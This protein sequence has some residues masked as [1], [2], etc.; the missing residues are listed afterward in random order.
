MRVSRIAG[1]S[2]LEAS[3]LRS[4]RISTARDLAQ[5]LDL[6]TLAAYTSI[7]V[8]RIEQ[9]A[10][11]A[12]DSLKSEDRCQKMAAWTGYVSVCLVYFIG[13][14]GIQNGISPRS[15]AAF[16]EYNE[17]NQNKDQG[18]IDAAI[19]NYRRAIRSKPDFA[20][21]YDQLGDIYYTKR[22]L[23]DAIR[24][25][26]I[27]IEYAPSVP[28]YHA[29]L[30]FAYYENH[31]YSAAITEIQQAISL[32][33]AS[34]CAQVALGSALI[35]EERYKEAISPLRRSSGTWNYTDLRECRID[36]A[37]VYSNLGYAYAHTQQ[38][39]EAIEAFRSAIRLRSNDADAHFE[40]GNT[41][42]EDGDPQGAL[43]EYQKAKAIN[44]HLD[45]LQ[46]AIK[47]AQSHLE[48]RRY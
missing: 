14:W 17:G 30:G 34:P 4:A 37:D 10:L 15:D 9:L 7:P 45:G 27:A 1:I 26:S 41:I 44:P 40:L 18:K 25:W 11:S 16:H 22:Q 43:E 35:Q 36:P 28:Q 29:E 23:G 12:S 31:N 46:Q 39:K 32:G 6:C 42:M 38:T 48:K 47:N 20:Y 24:E 21:P 19:E 33:E 5:V 2:Y 8:E 3:R 13:L